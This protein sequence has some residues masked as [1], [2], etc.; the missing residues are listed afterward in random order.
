M[1]LKVSYEFLP[2]VPTANA[3]VVMDHFGVGFEMGRK[4]LA[5][6]LEVPLQAG[7]VV[8]FSGPSGSGKSSLMRAAAA[9]L[10]GVLN[11]DTLGLGSAILVDSLP[12]ST[13][14]ALSLL[15]SCGLGEAQ[16]LLR[17]PQELSDGQRYRFRLAL[18]L[19]RKP[20]WIVADEFTAALDRPLAKV[21]AFNIRKLASRLGVGCLLA[22]THEDIVDDLQP[23]VLVQCRLDGDV[24]VARR[25]VKKKR[26]SFAHRLWISTGSATDWPYFARWHYRSHHLGFIRRVTVLW[27]DEQPIG[28][29][30]FTSPAT[31]LSQRSKYFGLSGQRSR[32]KLQALNRQLVT[33]SRVVL[34]PT[35]RGAGMAAWFVRESCR[36]CSWPWIEA[37]AE[38]GH[39]N[40]FFERA[41][42]VRVG[43]T[44]ST[45]SRSR[46]GH[47]AIYGGRRDKQGR[48][49]LVSAETYQ[50]SRYAEPVYYI[51]D[52]R[53][54]S[55]PQK[56][57]DQADAA[58]NEH[59]SGCHRGGGG[60][61][62]VDG[63]RAA[64]SVVVPGERGESA[65]GVS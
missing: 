55:L 23:D 32:V 3:S 16:L 54:D 36:T 29:C 60:L 7:E 5:D 48:R 9:Q 46:R 43:V 24:Q 42:F 63:G 13:S 62:P 22:T 47:S 21:I 39:L 4:V 52:N 50:K 34:H 15:A 6:Q 51:F 26:I 12:L 28:V 56:S 25:N 2:K 53:P 37:L 57:R 64:T 27:L 19:S 35:Y 61:H 17:T 38:M 31:A 10:D 14:D 20:Q 59:R 49:R 30:V 41:G 65:I 44:K 8:L 40:P 33:L 45:I 58:D 11:A 18:A 1:I